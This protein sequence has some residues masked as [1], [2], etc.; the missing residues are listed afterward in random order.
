M[1]RE[2]RK[3]ADKATTRMPSIATTSLLLRYGY[4][5]GTLCKF[6]TGLCI[7]RSYL[8]I[9]VA[10]SATRDLQTPYRALISINIFCRLQNSSWTTYP[11]AGFL[12]KDVGLSVNIG[13]YLQK[14]YCHVA[15]PK[16]VINIRL[17]EKK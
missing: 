13:L 11:C 12:R 9:F 4:C 17:F 6:F 1:E 2:L 15:S 7:R 16:H 3:I 5:V 14:T 8:L 10:Q